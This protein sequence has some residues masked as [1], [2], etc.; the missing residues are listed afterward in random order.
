MLGWML[1]S[2]PLWIVGAAV[3]SRYRLAWWAT[4]AALDLTGT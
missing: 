4:A 3:G 1:A 2:A